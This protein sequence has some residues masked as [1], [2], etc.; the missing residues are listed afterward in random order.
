VQALLERGLAENAK[1]FHF[2]GYREL[3]AVLRGEL[4]LEAA[5]AAIQQATR[6]YAKRQLTWFRKEMGVHWFPGFGDDATLQASVIDW[7]GSQAMA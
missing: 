7:L 1:P 6:H 3:R 5:C 4:S 2:I